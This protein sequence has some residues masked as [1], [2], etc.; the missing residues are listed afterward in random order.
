MAAVDAGFFLNYRARKHPKQELS[1]LS[2]V[3]LT[4]SEGFQANCVAKIVGS[5]IRSQNRNFSVSTVL[6]ARV[7]YAKVSET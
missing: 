2:T 1:I 6:S 7:L 3:N 5:S 4:L